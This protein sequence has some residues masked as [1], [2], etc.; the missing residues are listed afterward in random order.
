MEVTLIDPLTGGTFSDGGRTYVNT[1]TKALMI[2]TSKP[3][4]LYSFAIKGYFSHLGCS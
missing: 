2:S 3:R 1:T 4:E